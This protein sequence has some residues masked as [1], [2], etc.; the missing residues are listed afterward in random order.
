[1][2]FASICSDPNKGNAYWVDFTSFS[3]LLDAGMT[4]VQWQQTIL[5][6]KINTAPKAV[7]IS[8]VHSPHTKGL[9]YLLQQMPDIDVYASPQVAKDLA[10]IPLKNLKIIQLRNGFFIDHVFVYPFPVKH[11]TETTNYVFEEHGEKLA[12]ITNTGT[13]D[14]TLIDDIGSC[15]HFLIEFYYHPGIARR[16][17]SWEEFKQTVLNHGHL[18]NE[19]ACEILAR[20]GHKKLQT[21]LLCNVSKYNDAN[22]CLMNAQSMYSEAELEEMQIMVAPATQSSVLLGKLLLSPTLTHDQ[23]ALMKQL[24][25][26]YDSK[27]SK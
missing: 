7:F 15:H 11:G 4:K 6:W 19:D 18:T 17:S 3:I 2:R 13:I 22:L 16:R 21:I 24:I 20:C 8:H 27:N 14:K 23:I 10:F 1:M 25:S 5:L 12:Y 9:K 26:F